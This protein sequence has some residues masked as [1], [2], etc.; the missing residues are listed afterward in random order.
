[1]DGGTAGIRIK[2]SEIQVK[3]NLEIKG[4]VCFSVHQ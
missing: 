2:T 4:L 1:M 3:A